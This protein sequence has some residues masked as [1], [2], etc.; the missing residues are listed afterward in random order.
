MSPGERWYCTSLYRTSSQRW[1]TKGPCNCNWK[2]FSNSLHLKHAITNQWYLWLVWVLWDLEETH[3]SSTVTPSGLQLATH[4]HLSMQ[5][6]IPVGPELGLNWMIFLGSLVQAID[7][8]A[9]WDDKGQSADVVSK[10][11]WRESFR[12]CCAKDQPFSLPAEEDYSRPARGG[13]CKLQAAACHKPFFNFV[14]PSG[15]QIMQ[16]S[17]ELVQWLS[18]TFNE[19]TF[20]LSPRNSLLTIPPKK[21]LQTWRYFLLLKED[22]NICLIPTCNI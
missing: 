14:M 8:F 11:W 7:T 5:S 3:A 13:Q 2:P 4:N 9:L 15:G 6:L 19:R 10:G 1:R 16:C 18:S 22:R 12:V 20:S 21:C 17:F